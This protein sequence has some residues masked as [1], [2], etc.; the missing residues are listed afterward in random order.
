[1]KRAPDPP[2][3]GRGIPT[4][5]G[6]G[7]GGTFIPSQFSAAIDFPGK[8]RGFDIP[9]RQVQ[10]I[11]APKDARRVPV[12]VG[13]QQ[14]LSSLLIQERPLL[15]PIVFVPSTETRFLFQDEEELL[16]PIVEDVGGC[17]NLTF[18]NF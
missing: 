3:R 15:R 6:R 4:F 7:R 11:G 2:P 8:G 16:Q 14:T 13:G 12:R 9:R 10:G 5:R 18:P 1:M 17:T